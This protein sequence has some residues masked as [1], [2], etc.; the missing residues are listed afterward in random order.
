MSDDTTCPECGA[1][2]VAGMG[3]VEMFG[4]VLAWEAHDPELLAL[5]FYTVAA[6]NLQ[7][8]A[9]FTDE[10]TTFLRAVFVEAW[11]KQWSSP[12]VRRV[13]D[14]RRR[15]RKPGP[16]LRKP[17]D[18]HPVLKTWRKTLAD[19]YVPDQPQGA[20]ERVRAWAAAV[21]EGLR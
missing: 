8:P 6:Y 11:E 3:C 5:H 1:P 2:A 4:G 13:V 12:E 17:A 10:T 14:G 20:A 16:V 7:H 18:R 9:Q 19:V 15:A 21:H